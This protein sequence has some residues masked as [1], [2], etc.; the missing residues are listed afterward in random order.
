LALTKATAALVIRYTYLW[1]GEYLLGEEEGLKDRPCA[2][3]MAVQGK[4]G[5]DI[6]TVLPITHSAP[7]NAVDA[8]EIP[9]AT[10]RRLGLDDLPSWVVLT[11][12][13]RFAWPGPGLR[14]GVNGAPSSVAYGSL[15]ERLFARVRQG[16]LAKIRGQAV[17][18]VN[19]T[20]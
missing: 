11:E 14:P 13:N 19:R 2:V 7:Q 8:I 6:V 10:K 15:P 12:A 17:S 16:L 5:R 9:A 20:E 4:D 1:H 3:V 18:L